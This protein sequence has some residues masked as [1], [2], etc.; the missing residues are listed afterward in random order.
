MAKILVVDDNTIN[1]KL[2]V[3]LLSHDGH[4]TT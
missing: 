2:L 4:L 1:R 3:A